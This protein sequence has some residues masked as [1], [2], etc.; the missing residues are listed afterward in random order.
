MEVLINWAIGI[1]LGALIYFTARGVQEA[2][3]RIDRLEG[4]I[5]EL[6]KE[7]DGERQRKFTGKIEEAYLGPVTK[8]HREPGQLKSLD[9]E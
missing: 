6:A 3:K 7:L 4:C 2:H 9:E 5:E 1:A 8:L